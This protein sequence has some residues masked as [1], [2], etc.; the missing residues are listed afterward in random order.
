MK[1]QENSPEELNEMEASKL[2]DIEF[3]V[4]IIR[5]LKSRKKDIETIKKDQTEIK[6]AMAEIND[7]LESINSRLD[8]AED[9]ISDLEGKVEKNTQP[10]E[11]KEKK[12][13]CG[14]FKKPFGQHEA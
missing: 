6:N 1:E 8:R 9:W 5:M 12:I 14:E 4:M 7:T 2:S 11:Q 3:K 13:K 10:E